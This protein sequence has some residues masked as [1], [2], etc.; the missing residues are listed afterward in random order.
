MWPD[1]NK[2]DAFFQNKNLSSNEYYN[3]A[4]TTGVDEWNLAISSHLDY[5]YS[6]REAG[7]SDVAED[8][9]VEIV[10]RYD[11]MGRPLAYP[12]SGINIIVYSDGQV[13]KTFVR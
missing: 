12:A 6:P 8:A 7:V 9:V 10:G 4:Y 1:A 13:R 3:P 2:G 11:I 5:Y